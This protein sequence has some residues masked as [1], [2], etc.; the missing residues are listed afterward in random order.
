MART[1]DVMHYQTNPLE[2]YR[3]VELDAR[4]EG[5]DGIGLTRL[6]LERALADLNVALQANRTDNPTV[7]SDALL[8]TCEA[9]LVLR[10]GTDPSS[11]IAEQLESFYGSL[12]VTVRQCVNNWNETTVQIAR[13]DLM[14]INILVSPDQSAA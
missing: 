9:L 13:G 7:R 11:P 5:S 3:R 2:S 6:C 4:V 10:G 1:I 8:R 14:D 12:Y